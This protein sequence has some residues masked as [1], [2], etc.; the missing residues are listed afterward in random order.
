MARLVLEAWLPANIYE[1]RWGKKSEN[2]LRQKTKGN[3]RVLK[4]TPPRVAAILFP[5]DDEAG[6][7]VSPLFFGGR[8]VEAQKT[9]PALDVIVR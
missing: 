4:K 3:G 6:K 5:R 8:S 1:E 7:A 2:A 9:R